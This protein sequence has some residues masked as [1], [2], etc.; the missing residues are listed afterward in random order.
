MDYCN[1]TTMAQASGT[2]FCQVAYYYY[3][4][5][6]GCSCCHARFCPCCGKFLG[7]MNGNYPLYQ[8]THSPLAPAVT[9]TNAVTETCAPQSSKQTYIAGEKVEE[10][11]ISI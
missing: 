8:L 9:Y 1:Q 11:K 4:Y 3:P 10:N 7:Y 2:G 5:N 6:N